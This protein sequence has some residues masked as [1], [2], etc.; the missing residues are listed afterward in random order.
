MIR[1]QAAK[2]LLLAE[3]PLLDVQ[4]RE[5]KA[6]RIFNTLKHR[7]VPA[8][9]NGSDFSIGCNCELG[10]LLQ[11]LELLGWVYEME[12]RTQSREAT[13]RKGLD[14]I[15]VSEPRAGW[16]PVIQILH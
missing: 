1:L 9:L 7:R 11:A 10:G 2:R 6:T 5:S 16:N 3:S 12:P 4:Q 13:M 14:V 8:N 15:H